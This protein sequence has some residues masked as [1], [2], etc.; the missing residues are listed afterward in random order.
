[1]FK[2]TSSCFG[3]F[4]RGIFGA[5][6]QQWTELSSMIRDV[7][8]N[9][10]TKADEETLCSKLRMC[11]CSGEGQDAFHFHQN[12]VTLLKPSLAAKRKPRPPKTAPKPEGTKRVKPEYPPARLQMMAAFLIMKLEKVVEDALAGAPNPGYHH[13]PPESGVPSPWAA[14]LARRN[15]IPEGD[16]NV[17]EV[18]YFH[19]GYMNFS[20]WHFA[21]LELEVAHVENNGSVHLSVPEQPVFHRILPFLRDRVNMKCSWSISFLQIRSTNDMVAATELVPGKVIADLYTEVPKFKV[22]HGSDAE[23]FNRQ[24][25]SRTRHGSKEKKQETEKKAGAKKPKIKIPLGIED[26]YGEDEIIDGIL[27]LNDEEEGLESDRESIGTVVDGGTSE[28]DVPDMSGA[29]HHGFKVWSHAKAKSSAKVKLPP[30]KNASSSSSVPHSK[31]TASASAPP[32]AGPIEKAELAEPIS[33]VKTG[34]E[35][36]F[37]LPGGIGRLCFY[38]NSN[39]FSAFCPKHVDCRRSRTAKPGSS[40]GQGRPLGHLLAWLSQA[41]DYP[42]HT[43]HVKFCLPSLENRQEGRRLLQTVPGWESFANYERPKR[44]GESDEPD[45]I[46]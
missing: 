38:P 29:G 36:R 19:I 11:V 6:D 28:E 33:K 35:V 31:S 46:R 44:A 41:A 32:K 7:E 21:G 4:G 13:S 27:A 23:C 24:R 42:D 12:L 1:M 9:S 39:S 8:K 17:P 18:L 2:A 16:S 45:E 15:V 43:E 22:W 10:D 34:T 26:A 14:V 25:R 20:N 5:M 37:D 3:G 40:R 30:K